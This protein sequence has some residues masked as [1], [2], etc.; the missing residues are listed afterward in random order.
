MPLSLDLSKA[1]KLKDVEFRPREPIVS[2]IN[3]TLQTAGSKN[4]RQIVIH[5]HATLVSSILLGSIGESTWLEWRDLDRLLVQLWITRS[6]HPVITYEKGAGN[7][8]RVLA[9]KLLPELVSRG[10]DVV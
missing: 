8:P 6:I 10:F 3:A 2:W 5:I 1:T 9:Q 4:L 7:G